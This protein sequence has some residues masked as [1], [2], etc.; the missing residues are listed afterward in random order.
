M[1]NTSQIETFVQ[2]TASASNEQ[3]AAKAT[4]SKPHVKPPRRWVRSLVWVGI[5]LVAGVVAWK[6]VGPVAASKTTSTVAIA[7]TPETVTV[8]VAP[9]TIRPVERNVAIVG[10]LWGREEITVAPKVEGRVKR[11]YHD[12]GD[13]VKPGDLLLEIEDTEFRLAVDEAQRA[14]DLELAKLGLR[15]PPPPDFDV[16]ELPSTR[17]TEALMKNAASVRERYRKLSEGA[18]TEEERERIETDFSVAQANHQQM[19]LE[20]QSTLAA[21]RY[22]LALLNSAQQRL[23]ETKVYVPQ[24]QVATKQNEQIEFVVAQRNISIGEMVRMQGNSGT[25]LFRL[26]IADQLKL[27]AAIPER[28]LGEVKQGQNVKIN[29]EAY[30]G[31]HFSGTVSRVNTTVDRASRTFTVEIAIPNPDRKLSAGS[32]AKARIITQE[33]AK[34]LTVPEEAILQ[35]AGVVK[36]YIIKDGKAHAVSVQVGEKARVDEKPYSRTWAEVTGSISEN[37]QV[38]TSGFNQ[39]SEGTPVQL[40]KDTGVK[41]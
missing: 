23:K 40:R 12:M 24:P 33:Q 27:Q 25:S 38:I 29:I 32:F 26:V 5:L 1:S 36:V 17:R 10:S 6:V 34:A 11:I 9:V 22:R 31:N 37:A 14:L 41:Q 7:T 2:R 39:L 16:R 35:F 30:P 18:R 4:A 20:A 28:H 15:T 3:I 8:T 13:K 21:V 19:I